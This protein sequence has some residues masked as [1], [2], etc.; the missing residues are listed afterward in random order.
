MA[1]RTW[2]TALLLMLLLGCGGNPAE[3]MTPEKFRAITTGMTAAEVTRIMGP[4][5]RVADEGQ[6]AE[7]KKRVVWHWV[8]PDGIEYAVWLVDGI[9]GPTRW[10]VPTRAR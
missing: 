5:M 7:G 1:M 4:A 9:V 8:G 2:L 6:T 10:Q 3:R